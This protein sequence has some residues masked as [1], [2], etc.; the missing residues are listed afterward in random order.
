MRLFRMIKES[1]GEE[2]LREV[3]ELINEDCELVQ[4]N[5]DHLRFIEQ[6]KDETPFFRQEEEH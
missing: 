2:G 5:R 6:L 3:F 4:L 1:Y